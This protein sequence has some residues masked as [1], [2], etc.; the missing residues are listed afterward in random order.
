MTAN[1]DVTGG[2]NGMSP[3]DDLGPDEYVM[4]G[5]L[6]ADLDPEEVGA[7]VRKAL[8]SPACESGWTGD[9]CTFPLFHDGDHSNEDP[10]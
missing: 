1:Y 2:L 7:A 4:A 8:G 9:R 3:D 10:A 5:I 6:P